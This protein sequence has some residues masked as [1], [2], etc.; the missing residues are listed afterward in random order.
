MSD[1]IDPSLLSGALDQGVRE[2]EPTLAQ[3]DEWSKNTILHDVYTWADVLNKETQNVE[4]VPVGIK[5]HDLHT[6]AGYALS[7]LN[8][9]M[10]YSWEESRAALH[11]WRGGSFRPLFYK[12]KRNSEAL[13][14]LDSLDKIITRNILG[15][16]HGGSHQTFLETLVGAIKTLRVGTQT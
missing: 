9:N 13:N 11:S 2:F 15:G 4:R 14:I 12:Y 16:S 7:H 1:I 10:N 8:M 6:V 3:L 5:Y